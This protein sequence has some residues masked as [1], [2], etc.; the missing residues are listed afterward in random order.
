MHN[1]ESNPI[2]QEAGFPTGDAPIVLYDGVCGLC[3]RL[4][5]FLLKRD[6]HDRFRFASL[7]SKFAEDL[8]KRHGFDPRDLDTVYV[9]LNYDQP[10]ER[11]LARSDAILHLLT[12]LDGVWKWARVGNILP[13]ALRDGI[14]QIVAHNRY[15]VFGKHES[16][17]LPEPKHR[18]K[19]LDV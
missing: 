7:Q 13:R 14:Y 11:L 1:L 16:C 4:N 9:A 17:L 19:F 5:Q 3:N 12:Q 15:R 10:D 18:S 8:L 6:T 2:A